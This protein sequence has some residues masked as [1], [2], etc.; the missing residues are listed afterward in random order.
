ML[1][2]SELFV[3]RNVTQLTKTLFS[4]LSFYDDCCVPDLIANHTVCL[5]QVPPQS[6]QPVLHSE[7]RLFGSKILVRAIMSRDYSTLFAA[8][9]LRRARYCIR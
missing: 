7:F 6:V 5:L 9:R 4:P 2:S 3:G 1:V 8:N